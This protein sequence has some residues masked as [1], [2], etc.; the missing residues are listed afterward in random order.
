MVTM[1][2]VARAAGVSQ[3]SVSYAYTRPEKLSDEQ[4]GYILT[5]ASKLGYP[6]PHIAGQSLKGQRI[7]A[8]GVMVTGTLKYALED[9]SALMVLRGIAEVGEFSEM[10]L[11]IVPLQQAERGRGVDMSA[12]R[13]TPIPMASP[14]VRGLVDGLIVYALPDDNH[15]FREMVSR[16]LPMVSIDGPMADEVP[17][18]TIDD[19]KAAERVFSHILEL[20]HRQIAVLV[21]RLTPALQHGVVSRANIEESLFRVSRER[22]LG[23]Q[24]AARKHGLDF[25]SVKV[26]EAG[27][28]H[29]EAAVR[30]AELA[31]EAGS[32]TALVGVNDLL[33]LAALDVLAARGI[34]VPGQV[35]VVGF[36]DNDQ[37]VA[38]GLT[39]IRQPMIEK[40]RIAAQL[41][42]DALAGG[43]VSSQL[44]PT[45]FVLRGTTAPPRH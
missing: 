42:I 16:K 35:S 29:H 10:P 45:E 41:L 9:P 28:F 3:A 17:F 33:A 19:R 32:P 14:V 43:E 25:R 8:I 30:A 27:G 11:T 5:V 15:V 2:D 39:T 1:R 26:I 37:A 38:R 12:F 24:D 13:K 21:D 23:Y 4:R 31:L 34:D 20:G 36:D 18:V 40:G 22:L 44:L 6:G 7:G